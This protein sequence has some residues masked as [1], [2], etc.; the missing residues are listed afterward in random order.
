MRGAGYAAGKPR[1]ATYSDGYILLSLQRK[2]S[3][4]NKKQLALL[5][6]GAKAWNDWRRE[7]PS[8]RI[9]LRDAHFDGSRLFDA[10]G[11][12]MEPRQDDFSDVKLTGVDL[13]GADL[14]GAL[15]SRLKLRGANFSKARFVGTEMVEIDCTGAHFMQAKL[16]GV[17]LTGVILNG[18][19]LSDADLSESKLDLIR[20][21]GANLSGADLAGAHLMGAHL[22]DANLGG[23]VLGDTVFARTDF[24]TVKNLERC[25]HLGPSSVDFETL[26]ASRHV[27]EAFWR[28]CGLP[29]ILIEYLHSLQVRPIEWYSCF[30]SYSTRDQAFADRV[31]ADLQRENVRCWFAPHFLKGGKKLLEQID[32][33]IRQHD[34]LLLILSDASIESDWVKAEITRARRREEREGRRVLFPVRLVS[35]ERLRDWEW[36]DADTGRDLAKEIREYHIPDF[37]QWKNHDAYQA[38]FVRLLHDLK[39]S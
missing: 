36:F 14:C 22:K 3:V 20:F 27:P 10:G 23:A 13:S 21:E 15:M 39:K 37:S 8:E 16:L 34:K 33:A 26:L 24:S 7:N 35:F 29:D 4:A 31:F 25:T 12:G 11:D 6:N 38:E 17:E 1:V 2:L 28:G 9:D 5:R 30:I 32:E 19:D 18:A